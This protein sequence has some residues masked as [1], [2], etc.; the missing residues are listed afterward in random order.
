[1]NS[2]IDLPEITVQKCV[3][4]DN[5]KRDKQIDILLSAYN[6]RNTCDPNLKYCQMNRE[7]FNDRSF[8]K[9]M[10]LSSTL[11][12]E[13]ETQITPK[14]KKELCFHNYLEARTSD[15]DGN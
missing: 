7:Y 11:F 3:L 5:I 4:H 1:M 2:E 14:P 12:E 10:I 9:M 13:P 6:V 15:I 8:T